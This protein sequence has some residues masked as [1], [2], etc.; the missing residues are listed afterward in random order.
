MA[1][2]FKLLDTNFNHILIHTGQHYDELL[3]NVFFKDLNIRKPD[4][5]LKTGIPGISREHWEQLSYLSSAIIELFRKEKINPNL[6]LFL[7]DSNSSCCALPLKKESYKIG[8]IEAGM[9]SGDRRMLE[10]INRIVCDH[11]SDL[12]FVYHENYKQKLESENIHDNIYVVGNTIVEVCLPFLKEFSNEEKIFDTVLIDIHRPENFK[13]PERLS[14]IIEYIRFISNKFPEIKFK[15]LDFPGTMSKL[16]QEMIINLNELKVDIIPLMGYKDYLEKLYNCRFIISDSGTA[17]EEPALFNVPVIVP[18]D[19][20]ERPESVDYGCSFMID[21]NTIN[22]S[23]WNKSI[24]YINN[25]ENN[26][27]LIDSTWLGTG[28]TAEYVI[29]GIKEFLKEEK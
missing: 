29:N 5:T 20:T 13:Y 25:V 15:M 18:R 3:S 7:G 17:Q 23:S 12:F 16:T 14:N 26:I 8:H 9:R 11:C 1:S 10:E 2:I 19:F 21:V 27:Q 6:I 28:H 4:F 22:N 24:T